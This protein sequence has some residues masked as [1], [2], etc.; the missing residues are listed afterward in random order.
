M[1][2][3]LVWLQ[4]VPLVNSREVRWPKIFLGLAPI[5]Q[6]AE[7]VDLKSIQCGFESHWG[8]HVKS[9]DI[10]PTVSRDFSRQQVSTDFMRKLPT[11]LLA[12]WKEC[13]T[14]CGGVS[15]NGVR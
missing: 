14:L 6:S 4:R 12:K 15:L 9:R 5:A 10:V 1:A 11:K 2:L 8:H 7:A 13:G 3:S